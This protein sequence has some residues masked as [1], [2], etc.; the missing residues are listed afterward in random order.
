M[1][2]DYLASSVYVVDSLFRLYLTLMHAHWQ[3]TSHTLYHSLT[4]SRPLVT[5]VAKKKHFP[6]Q[7]NE[8]QPIILLTTNPH[9][10]QTPKSTGQPTCNK[11]PSTSPANATTL[12]SQA[13]QDL[14][15]T[16]PH[17][18]TFTISSTTSPLRGQTFYW[19]NF[20]SSFSISAPFGWSFHVIEQ[21]LPRLRRLLVV[22]LG[23]WCC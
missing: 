17:T 21:V 14:S 3:H 9:P 8:Q 23:C 10:S 1:Q 22:L 16:R 20:S 5:H 12:F 15:S 2:S 18:S 13:R 11:S 19:P 4:H 7:K 6:F